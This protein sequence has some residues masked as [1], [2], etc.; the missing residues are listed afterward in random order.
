MKRAVGI[1]AIV[2]SALFTTNCATEG[3]GTVGVGVGWYDY[4]YWNDPWYGG[5]CCVDYPGD[6]GPPNPGAP[7][8]E[9]PIVLPPGSTPRPEQPIAKPDVKPVQP[10]SATQRSISSPRATSMS[11]GGMGG[12]GGGGRGGGGRR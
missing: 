11:R 8:P 3:A 9:H 7:R 12:M 10:A 5:G 6:I 1:A 4:G 2:A